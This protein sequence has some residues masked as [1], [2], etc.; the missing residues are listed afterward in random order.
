MPRLSENSVGDQF[1]MAQPGRLGAAKHGEQDAQSGKDGGLLLLRFLG[2]LPGGGGVV[3]I[4]VEQGYQQEGID[5]ADDAEPVERGVPREHRGYRGAE[6][7]HGLAHV[8]A[9]HVDADGQRARLALVPVG[10]QGQG[11]GDVQGLADAHDGAEPIELVEGV[12]IAHHPRDEGPHE[13]AAH[14]EPFAAHAVGHHARHGA[15]EAV[16]PQDPQ[17]DGHQRAKRLGLVQFDDIDLHG[18]LHGGEHL[19]V[20]IVQQGHHPE[21]AHYHPRIILAVLHDVIMI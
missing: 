6:A 13:E 1:L 5:H 12:G 10:Y 20:H 9:R 18:L 2:Q 17:E 16:D 8:E 3:G 15:E 14:H 4:L 19:A 7:A 21:E 11:G